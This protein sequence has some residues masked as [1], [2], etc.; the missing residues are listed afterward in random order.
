MWHS[1]DGMGWWMLFGGSMWVL[2]IILLVVAL[3]AITG[4]KW[5]TD[6][7]EDSKPGQ[8]AMQIVRRRY[9]AGEIS[10]EE[11]DQIKRDLGENSSQGWESDPA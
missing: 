5:G 2:F 3:L 1:H 4:S 9:A 10:R 8:D 6:N 11:F 7:Q